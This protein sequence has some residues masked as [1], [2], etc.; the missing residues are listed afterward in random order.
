MLLLMFTLWWKMFS[1]INQRPTT[2]MREELKEGIHHWLP[3]NF[4]ILPFLRIG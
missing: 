4:V 1:K 3:S 2:Q